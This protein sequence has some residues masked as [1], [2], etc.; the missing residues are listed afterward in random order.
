[1]KAATIKNAVR[2]FISA[3]GI[4]LG[5][6]VVMAV[7]GIAE[8]GRSALH[9]SFWSKDVK[10]YDIEVENNGF[11]TEKYLRPEDGRLLTDKMP[12]VKGTI[13]VLKLSAKLNSYKASGTALT[14]AVNENFLQYANL[15]M[16]KGS[17]INAGNVRKANKIAVID[18][19]TALELFGSTSIIGQKLSLEIEGKTAK[20]LVAGVFKNHNKNVETLFE[21]EIP[22]ICLIPDSVPEDVSFGF[23]MEKLVALVDNNLHREEAVIKLGHLLEKEHGTAGMYIINEYEQLPEVSEFTDKYLVF[24]VI[25]ALVGLISGGIGV[26]NAMLLDIQERKKEIGI[27]KFYGSGIKELQYNIIYRTLVICNGFGMLGLVLGILAGSFIGSFINISA[28]FTLMS[29]FIT[30]AASTFVG[31]L[32]SLYPASRI[33]LVDA[34]E[35]IWGE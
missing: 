9:D 26:M 15:E 8:G 21:D 28:R 24:S 13:P 34:S 16:L 1:M 17:F 18:D 31:I 6:A 25:I 29:I 10:I 12:E 27:Y 35:A 14:L 5:M 30:S 2:Y 19:L 4:I 7:L 3:A 22:G 32:S 20:F 23:N 33:K 11:G